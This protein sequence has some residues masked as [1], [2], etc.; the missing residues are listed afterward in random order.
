MT[1]VVNGQT[2]LIDS[3]RYRVYTARTNEEKLAA[4]LSLFEEFQ[5]VNRD[6]LDI[7]GPQVKELADR[8]NNAR[9]KSLAT[10]A[11]ANW[12]FRWGWSDSALAFIEPELSS[13]KPAD[14]NT[15]D[16]YFKLSRA[17]AIYHGSKSRYEEAL[18]VLYKILP[19]AEKYK[20]T[21]NIGLA[22]N[23]IGSIAIA[24]QQYREALQWINKAVAVAGNTKRYLQVL[25]PALL[26]K[27]YA[28]VSLDKTDS[29]LFFINKGLL[30]SREL[31]NLNY[32]ATAL[33]LQ[34]T[35]YTAVAKYEEAERALLE[36]I[37]VR[38]STSPAN[39]VVE[40]NLQLA[41][42]YANSGQIHKAIELCKKSLAH[43]DLTIGTAEG[44]YANDPKIRLEYLQLLSGYYK[45]AGMLSEYQ[46][47]LE[48]LL[49]TKDSFYA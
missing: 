20:D 5:S 13:N 7:Y 15:R 30:L 45:K 12:Y 10:L 2:P 25:A 31:Q 11:Y 16:I 39:Q 17:K 36:M 24:R 40:D 44:T 28:Y 49:V 29:A 43:G 8:S 23:S 41:E 42:F 18:A 32:V 22:S 1:V 26:N 21:S 35:A 6:S 33:R 34:A 14:D 38:K 47:S 46:S 3:L 37:A 9:Y 27:G 4:Y 19:E 48:E